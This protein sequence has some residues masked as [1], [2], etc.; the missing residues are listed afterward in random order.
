MRVGNSQDAEDL[1]AET[2]IKAWRNAASFEFRGAPFGAWLLR[3]A[4]NLVIDRYRQ[5][6]DP[7]QWL[8]WH[9]RPEE[10]SPLDRADHRDEIRRAISSLSYLEQIIVQLRFFEGYSLK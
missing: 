3:I 8:P 2:F 5:K 6:R 1:T 7:S 10:S 4:H 9:N